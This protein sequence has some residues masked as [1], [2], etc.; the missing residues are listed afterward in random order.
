MPKTGGLRVSFTIALFIG[1]GLLA[2]WAKAP[3]TRAGAEERSAGETGTVRSSKAISPELQEIQRLVEEGE[4]R[5]AHI[6][7]LGLLGKWNE[8]EES[9]A[10][11]EV[12]SLV[13]AFVITV[14]NAG[15]RL[16][17][18]EDSAIDRLLERNKR[19]FGENDPA[20]TRALAHRAN[21]FIYS[22]QYEKARVLLEHTLTVQESSP[23]SSAYDQAETLAHLETVAQYENQDSRAILYTRRRMRLTEQIPGRAKEQVAGVLSDLSALYLKAGDLPQAKASAE[24]SL[25]LREELYPAG[26]YFVAAGLDA[27]ADVYRAMGDFSKAKTLSER[28]AAI[29]LETN[30]PHDGTYAGYLDGLALALAGLGDYRAALEKAHTALTIA[31]T[32]LGAEDRRIQF[33]LKN[34]ASIQMQA[35]DLQSARVSYLRTARLQEKH[36][37]AVYYRLGETLAG[38]SRV[39]YR[40][41]EP[42]G[43][44]EHALRSEEILRSQFLDLTRLLSESQALNYESIRDTGFQVTASVLSRHSAGDR[45]VQQVSA[46]WDEL[47][48]SRALI[49]EEMALRQ[50]LLSSHDSPEIAALA[51]GLIAVRNQI[52]ALMVRGPGASAPDAYRERMEE[53]ESER[54]GREQALAEMSVEFSGHE[55]RVRAGLAEVAAALP[56]DGAL[57][58][59]FR[60]NRLPPPP[61]PGSLRLKPAQSVA[62]YLAL[63]LRSGRRHPELVELGPAEKIDDLT[64]RWLQ[65]AGS[66]APSLSGAGSAGEVDYREIATQLRKAIWDPIQP[67]V[68]GAERVFVVP[69]GAI[70]LVNLATLPVPGHGYLI[71]SGPM[72]HYL[73]A[74]RDLLRPHAAS[75]GS[76]ILAL[77]GPD[78]DAI[79]RPSD[80]VAASATSQAA[81][82]TSQA[83]PGAGAGAIVYRGAPSGCADFRSLR[84]DPLPA[85]ADEVTQL[86]SFWGDMPTPEHE[87]GTT[88][89]ILT[90]ARANEA[91]FKRLAPG[92]RVLHLATHG[93]FLDDRCGSILDT[94][95]SD[96]KEAGASARG[97]AGS[98]E[99]P[100]QLAGL[101]LAGAN[102]RASALECEDCEDGILT[103]DEIASLDL[104]SVEWAVLSACE[105]GVGRIVSGEGV[106][107]LRRSFEV[108]GVDTVIM[109]FWQIEDRST[110][111]WMRRLYRARLRGASTSEA[112]HGAAL[113]SLLA[114]RAEGKSTHPFYWGAFVAAGDWR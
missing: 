77:G 8:G 15:G 75:K 100:F 24:R 25:A 45:P 6:M 54:E 74:E 86:K 44:I 110:Q 114:L 71:E 17:P 83:A 16:G 7:A 78:F 56:S 106:M 31:E 1:A 80:Q 105:S 90:G 97:S 43:A 87:S 67:D 39:E 51:S 3:S 42:D 103:A 33:Y 109:S 38:L 68:A 37:G 4:F 81:A 70:N 92:H 73:S 102:R 66:V 96:P 2:F 10:A 53:M 48:R 49:L 21:L 89:Q 36:F 22:G 18:T 101:A 108:A 113:E 62:S 88:A 9:P 27:L 28:A 29:L 82:A 20:H 99:S 104:S 72:I 12:E 11:S 58:A 112:V 19:N 93:F 98:R 94:E 64:R 35:G 61:L 95:R 60:Y 85:A 47:I 63:T 34:L 57:V 13:Q 5:Q 107:G 59:Y 79:P 26:H 32:S 111:E 30:G 41:G 40:L 14:W 91:A 84:F 52:S 55:A 69:D 76:G 46:F 50:H 23:L 65:S